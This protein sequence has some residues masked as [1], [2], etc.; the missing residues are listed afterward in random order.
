MFATAAVQAP[1]GLK[2]AAAAGSTIFPPLAPAAGAGA[3]EA[4]AAAVRNGPASDWPGVRIM[5]S[6]SEPLLLV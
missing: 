1:I 3:V 6:F 5:D 2:E 4:T